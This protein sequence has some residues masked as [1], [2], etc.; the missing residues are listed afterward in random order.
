MSMENADVANVSDEVA[1]L[2][3]QEANPFECGPTGRRQERSATRKD[4]SKRFT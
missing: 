3:I 1:D 2:E 4:C